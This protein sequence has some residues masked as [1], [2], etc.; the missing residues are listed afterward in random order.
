MPSPVKIL[1]I[2]HEESDLEFL[3]RELKKG[4]IDYIT[5]IVD[6][7]PDVDNTLMTF[8]PDIILSD[9]NLPSFNGFDVFKIKAKIAPLTPF[10]FVSGAIGEENAIEHLKKGITDCVQKDKLFTLNTKIARALAEAS[11]RKEKIMAEEKLIKSERRLVRAQQISKIGSWEA[12]FETGT[13]IWSEEMYHI[14]NRSLETFVPDSES[15]IDLLHPDDRDSMRNWMAAITSGKEQTSEDFRLNT[16]TGPIKYLRFRREIIFD[17]KNEPVKVIGTVQ[18][19]TEMK[20]NEIELQRTVKE[21]N[22][23]YNELMQFSYIV[24]HNLR[25]P[26]ANIIGMADIINIEIISSEEKHKIIEEIQSSTIKMDEVVK[27]LNLI[28]NKRTTLNTKREKISIS[29]VI[30]SVKSLLAHQIKEAGATVKTNISKDARDISTI[31]S[32]F[33]SILYNL[34]NNAIKY[35]SSKRALKL[36]IS[37][38][39]DSDN[40]LIKVADNGMGIDL[41]RYGKHIFGLYKRFHPE[42]EG[43]GLGLYM[44]KTQIEV[45]GGTIAILSELD[46]GTTFIVTLPK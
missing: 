21:L 24:S 1:I 34:I 19:I 2:E 16:D 25:A 6:T 3:M 46:K 4:D 39:R 20:I 5:K 14:Y 23:R 44:T 30:I 12:D 8:N 40:I 7:L 18:D 42:I 31:K 43:K 10:I 17:K 26:I 32:Y 13:M 38:S 29:D 9:Y 35:K 22:N 33:E 36:Y 27:D 45:L 15:I 11:D 28:L 41:G 37:V